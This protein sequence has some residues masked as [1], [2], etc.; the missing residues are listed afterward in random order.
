MPINNTKRSI[1]QKVVLN[2]SFPSTSN[3]L[4]QTGSY[5]NMHL[6]QQQCVKGWL[7]YHVY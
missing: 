3:Q 2:T 5:I 1:K 7:W 6:L 4:T